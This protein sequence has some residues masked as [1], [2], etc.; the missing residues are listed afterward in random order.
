MNPAPTQGRQTIRWQG[1]SASSETRGGQ[2]FTLFPWHASFATGI[3]SIDEQHRVLLDILNQLAAQLANPSSA[4]RLDQIFDQLGDY[5]QYHF[6]TEEQ[7]WAA[8]FPDDAELLSHQ[9]EHQYFVHKLEQMQQQRKARPEQVRDMVGFLFQWLISHILD[10]DQHLALYYLALRQGLTPEQARAQADQEMARSQSHIIRTLLGMYQHLSERS[11]QSFLGPSRRPDNGPA[12]AADPDQAEAFADLPGIDT[13]A[14]LAVT[15]GDH[16]LY[17]KLLRLFHQQQR[18][19]EQEFETALATLDNHKAE[20]IAH[21]LKGVAANIGALELRETAAQLERACRQGDDCSLL[22]HVLM[23]ELN[24][25]LK[26]ISKVLNLAPSKGQA[27]PAELKPV[28]EETLRGLLRELRNRLRDDDFYALE[29]VEQIKPLMVKHGRGEE[30]TQLNR[31]IE[32][33]NFDTALDLLEQL[34]QPD[35]K[36]KD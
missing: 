21:S 29:F 12:K 26:G 11:L 17:L 2:A 32:V 19:F 1:R 10:G 5:A 3:D 34:I 24:P 15:N 27:A 6:Q 33:Y 35:P 28:Q 31:A 4:T 16:R 7:L 8:Q 36:R 20:R 30:W 23:D 9:A 14:G 13:S 22:L 18:D 25:V